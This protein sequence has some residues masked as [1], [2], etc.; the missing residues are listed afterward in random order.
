MPE[1]LQKI[2]SILT[3][4]ER[5]RR[6][7]ISSLLPATKPENKPEIQP[8]EH[9]FE[10]NAK[11]FQLTSRE[12]EIAQLVC[13]GRNNKSIGETLFISEKTVAKHVQNIF[14]KVGVSNRM[15]LMNRMEQ[16]HQTP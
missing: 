13:Q 16:P 15:E 12:V 9:Y 14:E 5:Q 7:F 1:L 6:V 2:H 11:R 3:S 4:S 10:R 8:V